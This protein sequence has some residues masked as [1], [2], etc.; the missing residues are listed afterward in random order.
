M[1]LTILILMHQVLKILCKHKV[2]PKGTSESVKLS[3]RSFEAASLI[4]QVKRIV[5]INS[6]W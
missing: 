1:H 5:K 3:D 2:D 6:K 4:W